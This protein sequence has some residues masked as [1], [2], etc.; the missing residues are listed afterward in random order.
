M[1]LDL[2]SIAVEGGVVT[3]PTLRH[4]AKGCALCK[5]GVLCLPKWMVNP[6]DDKDKMFFNVTSLGKLAEKIYPVLKTGM[7]VRV[8]GHYSDGIY[9]DRLTD[10]PKIGRLIYATRIKSFVYWKR[11]TTSEI[12]K[13][14]QDNID[15]MTISDVDLEGLPF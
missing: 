2:V 12:T 1:S 9:R 3:K 11:R 13:E 8:E 6:K 14:L 5:F 7:P 4:T 15:K 10:E